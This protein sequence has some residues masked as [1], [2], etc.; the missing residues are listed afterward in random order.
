MLALFLALGSCATWTSRTPGQATAQMATIPLQE[1]AYGDLIYRGQVFPLKGAQAQPTYVYER[2]VSVRDGLQASTSFTRDGDQVALIE[3]ALHGPGTALQEYTQHHF[4]VQQVGRVSVAQ[5][6]VQFTLI[7]NSGERRATESLD[8]PVVVGPTLFSFAFEHLSELTQG[9]TVPFRFAVPSRLETVGFELSCVQ[10][11][12]EPKRLKMAPTSAI[13]GLVVDPLFITLEQG[14]LVSLEGR[15]PTKRRVG[16]DWA[17][18]DARV[19]YELLA[20]YR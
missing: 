11:C 4:Q 15:V 1:S 8:L 3:T 17:D 20:D 10:P 7:D 14:K 13:I 5:G 6:Q 9:K 2:R 18:F 19:T 16:T 12:T